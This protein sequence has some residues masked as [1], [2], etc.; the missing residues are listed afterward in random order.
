VEAAVVH[1]FAI[2]Y[3]EDEGAA[4][5]GVAVLALG[6]RHPLRCARDL[7]RRRPGEPSLRA[8]APAARR[9]SGDPTARLLALGGDET[10]ATAARLARLAG[11][12][13]ERPPQR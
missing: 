7:L 8:L 5:R 2:A 6:A 12:P 3:R 4:V 1:A 9:L 11:H 13:L 10:R